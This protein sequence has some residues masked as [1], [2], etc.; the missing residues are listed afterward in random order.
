MLIVCNLCRSYV[1]YMDMGMMMLR[2]IA[3]PQKLKKAC[4]AGAVCL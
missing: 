4:L 1:I 2:R 3:K